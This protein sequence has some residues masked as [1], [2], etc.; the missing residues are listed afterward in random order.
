MLLCAGAFGQSS[1]HN[2]KEHPRLYAGKAE[3][4]EIL[5]KIKSQEWANESWEKLLGEIAPYVERHQ[6][7][8]EWITSRLAM[9]WEEGERYTQ[10]YIKG[11]DWDYGEGNAPVPTVRL[12]GMRKWND[13]QNVPLKDRIPYN[14]SG[15]MLGV[16]RSSGDK[17]PVL[18]PYKES[19]HMIRN[20][21][22]EILQLAEK[23]AFAYYLTKEEKYAKFSAD[24]LWTWLLGTYYMKP[25]LDPE[26]STGGLGGYAPGGIMGYY[27]YE[28]IHDDRQVPAATTY[29][30]VHDYM[31]ANPHE[32]LSQLDMNV[33]D[34][35]GDV[36]KRF[37]EIGLVRGGAKGNWN[38]NR[39]RHVLISMLVLEEDEYYNDGKGM[40][41]YIPYY[42]EISTAFHAPL[43]K[44]LENYNK[45]TGLWPESPGYASGMIG[46]LLE[47]ALPLYQAGINTLGE[48]PMIQ[49]AAMANLGWLD[50]RGNLVVFGDMRGGP[51]N[52]E[53]FERLLTYYTWEGITD[54][55]KK[56]ATVINKG[57]ASDQYDRSEVDWRRIILNQPINTTENTLPY[58]RAAYSP[59]H[60]HM[61]MR[62][63]NDDE[64][65]M[66][67]TLYGGMH[68]S[69]LS[70]NGLAWQFYGN[71]YALA[72]DGAAYE[73]YWTPDMG[74]YSGPV[75]SN[76]IVQGYSKG[77]ITVNAMDPMVPSGQF[78]N[79]S[80]TSEFC[81][82]ADV[83]ADEKR[84]LIAMIRTSPTSGYYLDI[85]RSDLAE[86]DY[87]HHN[88]G[89]R[90]TLSDTGDTPITLENSSI[91]N[92][93]HE[94]Y[95]F[96]ENTRKARYADD[97]KATWTIDSVA[98][99][100]N[101]DMWM[102]GQEGRELFVMDAP[103]T[104][105]RPDVTPGQVNKAP[106]KTPTL[107]VRQK[108][109]NASES[110]FVAVFE[111]YKKGENSL[112]AVSTIQSTDRFVALE[113]GSDNTRQLIHNA[114]DK[115][116][117][118]TPAGS[119]FQGIFGVVSLKN[120]ELTY[121][122]LGKGG[123]IGYGGYHLAAI[124]GEVSASLTIENGIVAYSADK[125]VMIKLPGGDKKEFSAGKN[126][127]IHPSK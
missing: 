32:H 15:D 52:Y 79:E 120:D 121:L 49:K 12:P 78:Y 68:G 105:L 100:L 67:F 53:V 26:E 20:N 54:E 101:V 30:F 59:F 126:I 127:R 19:G 8:P 11:Q 94:A 23:S 80:V 41:H 1:V 89:N 64:N 122:Y 92:P 104:T 71:G 96:F 109:N 43:P 25:P 93:P 46:A 63:G 38:V 9:Y 50:A 60:R 40:E 42:T 113:V 16:S 75:A 28:V 31:L 125:P 61:I 84:R 118:E 45:E 21:N 85:F 110:P 111:T 114:I 18:V 3:R 95:S 47:M 14:E 97:F 102:M 76:T 99:A 116:V 4:E 36:F 124:E 33:T 37:I 27:D 22:K 77:E 86:N 29:D 24:I 106:Q 73:S 91:E 117:Y 72:P 69:H 51:L 112:K 56:V 58:H 70:S 17:T 62:N 103:P 83:S 123:Q 115:E 107:L 55:A 74:Y 87:I 39:Y 7:D 44:I 34:L 82:F 90:M 81:S 65:G 5:Q 108:G 48:N 88:L 57:I 35:A 66:M 2:G 98:P 119:V 13:F 10:C 6:S